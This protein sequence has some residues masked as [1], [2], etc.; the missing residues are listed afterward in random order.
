MRKGMEVIKNKKDIVAII[1]YGDFSAQ[2]VKFFTP[3]DFSQQLA[4]Q[5]RKSGEIIPAHTH[6]IVKRDIHYTQEVLVIKKGRIRVNLYDSQRNCFGSRILAA[7]DI[8]LLA[9]GGHGFE[10]LED[11]EMVE[12][13]QGPYLGKADKTRFEGI[14]KPFPLRVRKKQKKHDT[15]E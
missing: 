8:I 12:I 4:F 7:G 6:N 13:K 5:S 9:S 3:G 10:M 14:E 15:G 1:I 11:A 2:G